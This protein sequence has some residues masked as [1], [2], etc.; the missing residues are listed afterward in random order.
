MERVE[1]RRG[2]DLEGQ[3]WRGEEREVAGQKV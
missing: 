1:L 2:W 3:K